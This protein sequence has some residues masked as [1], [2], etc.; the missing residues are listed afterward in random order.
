MSQSEEKDEKKKIFKVLHKN[1]KI[2][3]I[4]NNTSK[5][6]LS[7]YYKC[8]YC[9]KKFDRINLFEVHMKIHVSY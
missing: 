3:H 1:E 5:K 4:Q 8:I 6:N 2:Y 7:L 9:G